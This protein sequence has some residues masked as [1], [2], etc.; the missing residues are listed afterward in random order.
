MRVR[1]RSRGL[2]S[3]PGSH[4]F[5]YQEN[6]YRYTDM[7]LGGQQFIGEETLYHRDVCLWGMNY[8]G[9]T[10]AEG[11]SGDFLSRPRF[12]SAPRISPFADRNCT[13]MAV[14]PTIMKQTAAL[15]G[16]QGMKPSSATSVEYMS[17]C[18][19]VAECLPDSL[20]MN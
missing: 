2:S 5:V 9:R 4:E 17:A 16:S 11:F 15:I 6:E 3:R 12:S 7:Y 13:V 19:M 10:L 18:I 20:T 8:T 1:V 14:T